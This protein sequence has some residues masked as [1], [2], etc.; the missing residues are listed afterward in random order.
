M[1][2]SDLIRCVVLMMCLSDLSRYDVL[3][4]CLSVLNRCVCIGDVSVRSDQM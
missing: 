1:C 4:R 2:L 3:V